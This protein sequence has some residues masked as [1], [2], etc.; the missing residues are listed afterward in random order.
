MTSEERI[1][2]AESSIE[3]H[4]PTMVARQFDSDG[5]SKDKVKVC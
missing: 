1:R 2:E 3:K 5:G 4:P